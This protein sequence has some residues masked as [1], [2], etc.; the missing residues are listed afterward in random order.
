MALYFFS[1]QDSIKKLFTKNIFRIVT[2]FLFWSIVYALY[3]FVVNKVEIK[4]VIQEIFTGHYHM[5]FLFMIIGLYMIIPFLKK[6]MENEFLTKYFLILS[7]IFSFIIPRCISISKLVF[8][9]VAVTLQSISNCICMYFVFSYVFYFVFGYYINRI[10]LNKKKTTIIYLLGICGFALTVV[11]T[12]VVT[13]YTQEHNT[14]FYNDFS[15]NVFL[16]SLFV[17]VLIK[18]LFENIKFS[19][20]M[21]NIVTSLSKYSFGA[22]LAHDLIIM[23]LNKFFNLNTLTFNPLISIPMIAIIVIFISFSISAIFNNIPKFNKYIV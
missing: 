11:L 20:K 8:P 2:A 3:D 9:S 19:N 7:F 13:Q 10:D 4:L 12:N 22:Y 18:K 6:I 21:K 17:F 23:I 5:W 1:K 16:E 15:I 14:L